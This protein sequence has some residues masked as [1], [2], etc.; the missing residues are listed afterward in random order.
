M[1]AGM[2]VFV[3]ALVFGGLLRTPLTTVVAM[4]VAAAGAAC[5]LVNAVVVL[6]N[7]APSARV[8][9]T[10]SGLYT[11]GW[12]VGGFLGPA[13]VGAMVDLTGWSWMLLDIAAV[14]VAAVLIVAVVNAR[15]GRVPAPAS[16]P[17]NTGE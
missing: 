4:C 16:E 7:L 8:V 17:S 2:S 3:A 10:Y 6:W 12:S 15:Q 9:G 1:I 14:A 5:F 13:L 11:V